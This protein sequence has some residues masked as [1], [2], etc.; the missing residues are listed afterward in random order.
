[1]DDGPGY[2]C[3]IKVLILVE[4]IFTRILEKTF[5]DFVFVRVGALFLT[6]G[7]ILDD[8]LAEHMRVYDV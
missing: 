4:G 3:I 8:D 7:V 5:E 1:M 6:G 2:I